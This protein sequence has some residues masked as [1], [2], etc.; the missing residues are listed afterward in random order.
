M[1]IPDKLFYKLWQDALAQPDR[2]MYIAEYGY[3]EWF[4]EISPDAGE[5]ARI[6]GNIHDVA[7]MSIRDMLSKSGLTQQ[8]FAYKFCVP[9][10]TVENWATGK[11]NCADYDRLG[12]A[13]RLGF[14]KREGE[15][16]YEQD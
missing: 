11:R 10:R 16:R 8:A 3:P 13:E 1:N 12:F 4:D 6:L 9:L 5:V 7:H 2:D 15:S 14:I